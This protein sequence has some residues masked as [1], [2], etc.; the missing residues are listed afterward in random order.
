AWNEENF[1][2]QPTATRPWLAARYYDIMRDV[3]P[4]CQVVAADLLDQDNLPTW[5]A[6]FKRSV[7]HVP[8]LWG[9]HNY[10]DVNRRRSL[11][12]SWTL[13]YSRLVKGTIWVTE[14]GGIVGLKSPSTGRTIFPYSPARA[15]S[16]LRYLF[17]LLT[18]PQVRS[19]YQ[20]VYVY[21]FYG[22]WNA[23]EQTN[24]WD[25]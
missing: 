8:R 11:G 21:C 2:Y 24:R 14:G 22:A 5:L 7:K 4:R 16:S 20:R 10:Q 25:S 23:R 9:L 18:R 12:K 1:Y 3:C 6:K 13:R 17:G 19:R 15:A